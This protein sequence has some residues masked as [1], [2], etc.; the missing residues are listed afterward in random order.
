M[1]TG[2]GLVALVL[3]TLG[4]YGVLTYSVVQR[5]REIA[6]RIAL[7]ARSEDVVR[8][9]L[10]RGAL[11]AGVGVVVGIAAALALSR[12]ISSLLYEVS[13][14]DLPMLLAATGVSLATAL[15]A[16]YL[17]ARRAA[18]AQPMAVLRE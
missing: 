12:F 3:A 14:F 11:L 18:R 16:S 6:L 13:A 4:T 2:F 10:S 15:A 17:P 7:G 9:V 8:L 5:Q 1:L